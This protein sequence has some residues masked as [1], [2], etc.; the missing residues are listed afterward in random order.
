MIDSNLPTS[1]A[2]LLFVDDEPNIL[3]ALK[4][5]FRSTEFTVLMAENGEEGLQILEQNPVDLVISDM[6]MPQMDGAEFLSRVAERW[7]DTVR[8]LLTGYA[9]L[10]STIIAVNQGKIYSYCSKPWEDNDLKTLVNNALEKKRLLDERKQL[11][12]IINQQNQELKELNDQLE[13]KVQIRTEQLKLSL[14]R[15]D[16]AHNG[17]KKQFTNTIKTI[18]HIIEMRPGIK[19]GHSKYIAE[20]AREL[21]QRMDLTADEIKDILFA[22][23]LCQLGKMSLSD[24]LLLQPVYQMSVSAKKRYL[25]HGQEGWLLLSSIEQLKNAAELILHQHEYYDGSGEPQ[26]LSGES[27][28]LGSRIIAIVRDYICCLDGCLTGSQMSVENAK[29][30]LLAQKGGLYDPSLVDLFL[31]LLAESK[32]K[33][34]RPIIEISWTQ[35]QPGMEAVEVIHNGILYLKDQILTESQVD[36]ILDMRRQSKD[37]IVRVRI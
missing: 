28:P 1:P 27:I 30:H 6:R 7:P 2:T 16:N 17:L 31:Q 22:G 32:T 5:L 9:D 35:L 10:E 37:L 21:A 23:L 8:I 4:R 20:H 29:D 15:I 11:F 25:S 36:K 18:A 3:K 33:D 13:E 19:S 14:Q 26:G 34:E 24:S 12:A